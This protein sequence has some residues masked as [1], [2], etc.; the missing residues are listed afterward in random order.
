MWRKKC[1]LDETDL[2]HPAKA[3]EKEIVYQIPK[4]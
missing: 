4:E 3:K 1:I 2:I